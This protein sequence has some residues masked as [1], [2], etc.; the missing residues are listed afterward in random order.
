MGIRISI[1]AAFAVVFAAIF[2]VMRNSR[3]PEMF[4]IMAAYAALLAVFVSN[5]PATTA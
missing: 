1:I 5:P 3:T 2:S 4:A